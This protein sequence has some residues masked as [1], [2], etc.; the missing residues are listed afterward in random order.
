[1]NNISGASRLS[2]ASLIAILTKSLVFLG[3]VYLIVVSSYME[4]PLNPI[5]L[6]VL[7]VIYLFTKSKGDLGIEIPTLIFILVLI[8][9]SITSI[10]P[11]RSF[12]EVWLIG[13]GIFLIY[14]TARIIQLGFSSR[15]L[16]NF[17]LLIGLG[18]MIFSWLDAGRWYSIWRS[19]YPEEWIPGISFRLN[20]GNTIAA[21]YHGILMIG[22]ARLVYSRLRLER[23]A[24]GA[25]CLSAALLIFLSSSRGAYLGVMGGLFVL[26]VLQWNKLK[27]WIPLFQNLFKR[28]RVII[29]GVGLIALLVLVAFTTWY[30]QNMQSHPTHGA[31][32]QSRNEFWGPAWQAFLRSPWIGNG[33]YTFAIEYMNSTSVPPSPIFY[34]A[35][36]MYLDILSGSGLVG[37]LVSGWLM[38][39]LLYRLWKSY[40][41]GGQ[42][43][44]FVTLGALL[45]LSSFLVHSV[46][47]GL[48]L[49]PFAALNLCV[50]LGAAFGE[51]KGSQK[52]WTLAPMGLGVAVVILAWVDFCMTAPYNQG[53]RAANDGDFELA[54]ARFALATQRD[55]GLVLT[56]QQLGLAES[57]L[58]SDGDQAALERAIQAM[59]EAVQLDPAYSPN[60]ANLGALYRERGELEQAAESFTRAIELAQE[61]ALWYLNLGEVYELQGKW[62]LSAH[63][64]EKALSLEP[65]WK[66]DGFW[67]ETPFRNEFLEGWQALNPDTPEVDFQYTEAEVIRQSVAAPILEFTALKIREQDFQTAERLL[68]IVGLTHF[69]RQIEKHEWLWLK[70]EIAASKEEWSDA[71]SLGENALD[72]FRLQGAYGPGGAGEMLYGTGI[73]RRSLMEGELVPQ[74]ILIRLPNPWPQ[75]MVRLAGWY[76]NVDDTGNCTAT[77]DELLKNLPDFW[78]RFPDLELDCYIRR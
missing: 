78:Q 50:L 35:H 28:F 7:L 46:F 36:S 64:Y 30:L 63:N 17:L 62:D 1:M 43:A 25:Y 6:S 42:T 51:I 72:G 23:F 70:A 10:D 71:I 74:L 37:F 21:Y 26:I 15:T 60:L 61:W 41:S 14:F 2:I 4:G 18:F 22:V 20:G 54:S 12:Y 44:S 68:G 24:F 3:L 47:D 40:H 45:A 8:L 66:A 29:M 34:H 5:L 73:F 11:R 33:P 56:H 16:V 13:I 53:I 75:R 58:A 76:Q 48:Y 59:E 9:T 55:P 69:R 27:K 65:N 52:K 31:A 57:V 38:W 77:K 39:T 49:M 19:S 32:L 67:T